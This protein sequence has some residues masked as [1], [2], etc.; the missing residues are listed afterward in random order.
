M[1]VERQRRKLV[2]KASFMPIECCFLGNSTWFIV[3]GSLL[4]QVKANPR[5]YTVLQILIVFDIGGKF[6]ILN[7]DE[8]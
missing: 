4:L 8:L 1:E 3:A 5:F 7:V 2:N 6:R